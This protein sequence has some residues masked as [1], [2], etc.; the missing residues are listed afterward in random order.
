MRE[1]IANNHI[2]PIE[3]NSIGNTNVT[4]KL[5]ALIDMM[6]IPVPAP[7]ALSGK[8]SGII[9]H[10]TEPQEKAKPIKYS[11]RKR[12]DNKAED[13]YNPDIK[14]IKKRKIKIHINST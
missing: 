13:E 5:A 2:I 1:N 3:S 9:T 7:L 6:A 12:T 8:S 10:A 14:S 11:A 4:I